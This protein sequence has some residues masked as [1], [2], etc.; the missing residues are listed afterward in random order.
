MESSEKPHGGPIRKQLR[1][2]A[3]E[4]NAPYRKRADSW[5][6]DD[7]RKELDMATVEQLKGRPI[8]PH[9]RPRSPNPY[10]GTEY[11]EILNLAAKGDSTAIGELKDIYLNPKTTPDAKRLIL[12]CL[13]SC[14]CK[15]S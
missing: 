6:T 15:P 10:S 2:H 14:N 3:R 7:L 4:A 13:L 1:H 8:S 9:F 5:K 12:K 11:E